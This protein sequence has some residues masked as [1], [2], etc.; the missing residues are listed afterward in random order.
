MES[1]E[2]IECFIIMFPAEMW[3]CD[4]ASNFNEG[5]EFALPAIFRVAQLSWKQGRFELTERSRN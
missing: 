2:T 3:I 4:P 5:A 1:V